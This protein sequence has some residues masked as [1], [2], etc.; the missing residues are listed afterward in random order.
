MLCKQISDM[1]LDE[2]VSSVYIC[3]K[4]DHNPI[5][6]IDCHNLANCPGGKRAVEILD[7][8]TSTGLTRWKKGAMTKKA[9]YR[10][11]VK[12]A[13]ASGDPVKYFMEKEGSPTDTAARV[14]LN[15]A[16]KLYPDLF[17]NKNFGKNRL[18]DT[19]KEDYEEALASGDPIK[20]YMDKFSI[21]H[22]A[23]YQRYKYAQRKFDAETHEKNQDE[24]EEDISLEDFLNQHDD[25]SSQEETKTEV[26]TDDDDGFSD[27]LNVKYE[28]LIAE[29]EDL[30]KK[31]EWYDQAIK[32]LELVRKIF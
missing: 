6:C 17:K 10:E 30:L 8:M 24:P 12:K 25:S 11:T 13:V 1:T 21:G 26:K 19:M 15:R 14:R 22:D 16:K 23:A 9:K 32:S 4:Y 20:W 28:K 3:N 5:K 18:V 2:L 27:L 31:I 7:N 29:R